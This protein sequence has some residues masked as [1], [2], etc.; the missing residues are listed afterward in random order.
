MVDEIEILNKDSEDKHALQIKEAKD[1]YRSRQKLKYPD[2]TTIEST[3]RAHVGGYTEYKINNLTPNRPAVILRRMDYVYGDY[4]L[5]YFVN[6]KSAGVVACSG[7][8]RIHR[9][10]NWPFLIAAQFV[11]D[12]TLTIRQ[13]AL[14][15]GRDVNMFHIWVYQ[16]K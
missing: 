7:T 9:W 2:G 5:E 12:S 3:G 15:A 6:G 16:P 14:T 13:S 10:R 4:E 1:S 8:D 11:T